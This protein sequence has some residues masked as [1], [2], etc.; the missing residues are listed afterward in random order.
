MTLRILS[1]NRALQI[2]PFRKLGGK[3]HFS[4]GFAR[5]SEVRH[6][7]IE[8]FEAINNQNRENKNLDNPLSLYSVY[9]NPHQSLSPQTALLDKFQDVGHKHVSQNKLASQTPGTHRL[10]SELI[11]KLYTQLCNISIW[12]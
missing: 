9:R 5:V 1:G 3:C 12:A 4:F 2:M 8:K 7:Y 6:I 10:P 11:L